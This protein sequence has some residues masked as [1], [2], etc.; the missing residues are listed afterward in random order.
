MDLTFPALSVCP[1]RVGDILQSFNAENPALTWPGTA[2]E[3]IRGKFLYAEDSDH[4]VN[5]TGGAATI[6]IQ[7]YHTTGNHALTVA[8]MP[9]HGHL[10]RVWD[11]AGT[12]SN[13][14]YYNGATKTTHNGARLYNGNA[15]SWVAAG[16]TAAAAQSGLGDPSGTTD[17]VGSGSNHNHG[18]TGNSLSTTQSIM[19]PY[20]ACYMWKRTA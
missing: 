8:E 13:A 14:S 7:H 5:S 11:N 19:P 12:T 1:Y 17:L 2:W 3:A 15:S 9:K 20:T 6:N 16:S 18:N 4:A 10:I